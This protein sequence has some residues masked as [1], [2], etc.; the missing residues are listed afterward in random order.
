MDKESARV[1]LREDGRVSLTVGSP[2]NGQSHATTFA[3][4]CAAHLGVPLERIDYLS[5]DTGAMEEGTGTFGSRMAV[6]AGNAAARA[7][8]TLQDALLRA[9]EDEMD[10]AMRDLE[11][12]EGEVR[13]RGVPA[14]THSLAELARRLTERGAADTLQATH[15]FAPEHPSTF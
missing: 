5:G 11:I 8:K 3:Q 14:A 9:A 1:E 13:V 2:S 15:A 12:V 6:M 10:A 4:I 7:A